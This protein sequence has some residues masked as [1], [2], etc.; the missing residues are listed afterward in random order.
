MMEERAQGLQDHDERIAGSNVAFFETRSGLQGVLQI[1][2]TTDDPAGVRVRYRLYEPVAA[3]RGRNKSR[4]QSGQTFADRLK[5]A[6]MITSEPARSSALA[7]VANDAAEAGDVT[8]AKGAVGQ[9]A[10]N[11]VRDQTLLDCARGLMRRGMR[12]QAIDLATTIASGNMR[13]QAL[14]ELAR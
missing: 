3:G 8:A 1:S 10:N 14:S 13:D 9:I 7:R 12:R 11:S 2:G 4:Q 5:A 6:R